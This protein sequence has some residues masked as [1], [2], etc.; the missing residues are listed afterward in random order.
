MMN[1]YAKVFGGNGHTC[2][3]LAISLLSAFLEAS[4]VISF[5][6]EAYLKYREFKFNKYK[7]KQF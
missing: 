4:F 2:F 6:L 3:S 1:I 5:T 7:N